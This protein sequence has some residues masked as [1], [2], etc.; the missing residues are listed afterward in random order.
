MSLRPLLRPPILALALAV[1]SACGPGIPEP[2]PVEGGLSREVFVETLIDLR[3]ASAAW[4][5]RQL[6]PEERDAILAERG[7]TAQE[8][9]NFVESHG[10]DVFFMSSIWDEVESRLG[11]QDSTPGPLGDDFLAGPDADL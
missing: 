4:E 3:R 7:V 10:T 11:L 9:T 2:S 1:V 8:L 6:P 5:Y